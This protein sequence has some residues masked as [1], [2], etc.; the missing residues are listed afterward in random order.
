MNK[1]IGILLSFVLAM[2]SL[3]CNAQSLTFK[4]KDVSFK[5]IKVNGGKFWLG[6][7]STNP[8]LPNYRPE[9]NEKEISH[10]VS[11]ETYYIGETEVT[12]ALYEAVCDTNPSEMFRDP[13]YPVDGV[14]WSDGYEFAEKLNTILKDKLPKGMRFAMP[15]EIQWEWAAK[16]GNKSHNYVFSGSNNFDDVGWNSGNSKGDNWT[17]KVASKKPNELGIY[18]MSGNL[19]EYCSDY[20]FADTDSIKKRDYVGVRGGGWKQSD[21]YGRTIDMRTATDFVYREVSWRT[22]RLALVKDEPRMVKLLDNFIA[23]ESIFGLTMDKVK[24]KLKGYEIVEEDTLQGV[25][26]YKDASNGVSYLLKFARFTSD[27]ELRLATESLLLPEW[28]ALKDV[29]R[30]LNNFGFIWNGYSYSKICN[31]NVIVHA[32]ISIDYDRPQQISVVFK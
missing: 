13:Q 26:S 5:M 23:P 20:Y 3:L 1:G 27:N 11:V 4:V 9:A 22:I 31:N 28:C 12:Q 10:K 16:G 24:E 17:H 18:D 6:R 8:K 29:R 21:P 19:E 30:V 15:T 14:S 2:G 25:L 32:R 7:Q